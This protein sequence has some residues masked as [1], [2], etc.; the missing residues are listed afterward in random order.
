MVRYFIISHFGIS[1]FRHFCVSVMKCFN[2]SNSQYLELRDGVRSMVQYLFI[3]HFG[4][5]TFQHFCVSVMKCF[6]AS[7]SHYLELRNGVIS[8]ST[9]PFVD[10]PVLGIRHFTF[11]DF[12][13]LMLKSLDS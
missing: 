1:A 3:S 11:H 8:R 5:S 4:V 9:K 12:E 2:T 6:D 10:V 13:T 7:N